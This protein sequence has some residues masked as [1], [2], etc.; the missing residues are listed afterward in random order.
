MVKTRAGPAMLASSS[1]D[2]TIFPFQ[3]LFD[4][5]HVVL[6]LEW[7]KGEDC[8]ENRRRFDAHEHG[9]M[10]AARHGNAIRRHDIQFEGV[11]IDLGKQGWRRNGERK[12]LGRFSPAR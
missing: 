6:L 8:S 7:A 2:Q 3:T 5:A 10:H 12:R 11:L 1:E 9:S 4:Q